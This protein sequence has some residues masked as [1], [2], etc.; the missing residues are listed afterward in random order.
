M[1]GKYANQQKHLRKNYVRFEIDLRPEILQAFR[2][3]C[4]ANGSTPTTELKKFIAHYLEQNKPE[5]GG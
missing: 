1:P 4:L 5:A 3:A 2:A